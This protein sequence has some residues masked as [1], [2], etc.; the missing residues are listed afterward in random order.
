MKNLAGL[1][2]AGGEGRRMGYQNKGLLQFGHQKLINPAINVL[3]QACEYTAISANQNIEEYQAF[4]LNIFQDISPWLKCGPLGGVCSSVSMFPKKMD[5]IQV[6]P[7]DSPFLEVQVVERLHQQLLDS[8]DLACYA[9]TESQI[10]PVIFQFKYEALENLKLFLK[11]NQKK[12][13]RQWLKTIQATPVYFLNETLFT[14]VN[15]LESLQQHSS[16][17]LEV[18]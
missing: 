17:L 2:L 16:Q 8:R 13:I 9:A 1:V 6:F 18:I 14:N 15:D 4:A 12:S 10:H 7:C 5:F 3:K 11:N